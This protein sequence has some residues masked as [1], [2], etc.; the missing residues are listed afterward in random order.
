MW[1]VCSG[2]CVRVVGE[3]GGPPITSLSWSKVSHD[4][5]AVNDDVMCCEHTGLAGCERWVYSL[6]I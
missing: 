6:N 4:I 2:E 3:K 1:E 5:T